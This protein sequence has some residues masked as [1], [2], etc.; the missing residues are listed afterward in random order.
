[1][2]TETEPVE[3]K[4]GGVLGYAVGTARSRR[5]RALLNETARLQKSTASEVFAKILEAGLVCDKNLMK[6]A[7]AKKAEYEA[8]LRK[9]LSPA[10][11]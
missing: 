4:N 2:V 1:M 8:L 9:A 6:K 11:S 7:E 10:K 3:V 5:L